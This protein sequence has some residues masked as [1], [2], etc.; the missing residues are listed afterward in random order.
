MSLGLGGQ[1]YMEEEW[2]S[3]EA[4]A[5]FFEA[6]FQVSHYYNVKTICSLTLYQIIEN[7]YHLEKMPFHFQKNPIGFKKNFFLE[8]NQAVSFVY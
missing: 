6:H 2:S 1:A 5:P 8:D 7:M 4:G 3:Q